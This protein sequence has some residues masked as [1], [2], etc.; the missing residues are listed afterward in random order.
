MKRKIIKTLAA[1]GSFVVL[2]NCQATLRSYASEMAD[3]A[4]YTVSNAR[5]CRRL[6][7]EAVSSVYGRERN[8]FFFTG[9]DYEPD[10]LIIAQM[11]PETINISNT[12]ILEYEENGKKYV[13]CRIGFERRPGGDT[14]SHQWKTE[15]LEEESCLWGRKEKLICELCGKEQIISAAPPG[16]VDKN[17]DTF[18]DRCKDRIEGEQ[19]AERKYWTVGEIQSREIGGKTYKFRCVDED[20]STNHSDNQKYALFLC[21]AVIRSD[22]D[23]TDSKRKII[24]FGK[25]SNYKTSDARKWLLESGKA[26]EKDLAFINTGVNSA[27]SGKTEEGAFMEF[28]D[29][30]L[31]KMDLP[32]QV[33]MDQ[34][35]LLSL[36]EALEYRDILWEVSGK[37]SPYSQGYWLRTPVFMEESSNKFAYGEWEYAVDLIRGCIR[38]VQVFDGAMGFRPAYCLPQM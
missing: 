8:E 38:P 29:A 30:E 28:S 35:F 23:S 11:F 19:E 9:E 22:I 18:C 4:E 3:G 21:E 12:K 2:A 20:Y 13:T 25:T 14:C 36:E 31:S 5:E 34:W 27:F 15:S 17:G 1:A 32:V 37:E 33:V 10:T 7:M 24:T 26:S 6:L 16:H